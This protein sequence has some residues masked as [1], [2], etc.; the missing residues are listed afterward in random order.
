M[1]RKSLEKYPGQRNKEKRELFSQYPFR[2]IDRLYKKKFFNLFGNCCFK[3]GKLEKSTQ[4]IGFPPNLC[5]DHHIPMALG[6]HLIPG[7]LVSLCRRCN[8]LKL[9][10]SPSEFYK[11]E[12]LERLQPLLDSQEE[13]F[14]F[15]FDMDKW[16]NNKE[17]YLIELG[18]EEEVVHAAL[19]DEYSTNYIGDIELEGNRVEITITMDQESIEK[20]LDITSKK[21]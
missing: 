18:I 12:E 4:E 7:N 5:M 10:K 21:C 15:S 19:H 13:L 14:K 8:G 1:A 16:K 2:I 11:Q 6:G 20:S 17:T 9:D 3:C